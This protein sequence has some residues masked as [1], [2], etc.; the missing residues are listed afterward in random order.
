[1]K[2]MIIERFDKKFH[3]LYFLIKAYWY[4]CEEYENISE[5]FNEWA[6]N[7]IDEMLERYHGA[8]IMAD[9]IKYVEENLDESIKV[10]IKYFGG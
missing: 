2:V 8:M 6:N 3:K 1:M 5:D 9:F 10:Y 4:G 7:M